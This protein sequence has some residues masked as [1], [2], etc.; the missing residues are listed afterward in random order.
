MKKKNSREQRPADFTN[1]PFRELKGVTPSAP[2]PA[3]SPAK[4]HS[5]SDIVDDADL[6]RNAMRGVRR[7][8]Q[9]PDA[10]PNPRT[11]TGG[12][13]V[14]APHRE[15][16]EGRRL[17]I[18]AMRNIGAA[19]SLEDDIDT[20]DEERR[21]TSSRM[22]RLKRG[23]IRISEE[24]DL[25]G[26]FKD[27]A[28][29]QL[30]QFITGAYSRH[31]QAVLVITGKGINSPDGPVLQGAVAAWLREQGRGLVAE[32]GP[33]PRDKGGRGAFVVFLKTR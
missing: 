3:I 24:L 32:F 16:D 29:A 11:P 12:D 22:R 5:P 1:K 8:M 26:L 17:F 28:I 7:V 19:A 20:D 23:M 15:D 14:A 25:H 33:A 10:P 6:F 9:Q 18:E 31:R 2:K 21:S 27:D 13:G 30:A 4:V